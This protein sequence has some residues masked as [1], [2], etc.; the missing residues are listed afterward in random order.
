MREYATIAAGTV[1]TSPHQRKNTT[2]KVAIT[3]L[4]IAWPD[5]NERPTDSGIGAVE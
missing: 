4:F 2:A 5:G 1:Y 3:A